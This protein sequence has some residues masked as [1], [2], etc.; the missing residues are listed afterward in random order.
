MPDKSNPKVPA[1]NARFLFR[2][3]IQKLNAS[4]LAHVPKDVQ[5]AIVHVDEIFQAP[6]AF[7]KT[8]GKQITVK[9]A[10][11]AKPK[12]GEQL[13]FHA[14]GWLFG[15][16]VA[17][18]SL[19]QEKSAPG[20]TMLEE[21][22]SD[23]VRNF[24]NRE[25]E[26]RVSGAAMVVEGQVSSIHLPQAQSIAAAASRPARPVSEHDPKWREAVV[27]VAMVHKGKPG[28]KQVVIRFPSSTDVQWYRA[29]KFHTGDRGV[30][31]LQPSTQPPGA[32]KGAKRGGPGA[33]VLAATAVPGA[34][35]YTALHPMDFHPA[36]KLDTVASVIRTAVASQNS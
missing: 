33:A 25:L 30:W 36:N 3:T 4:L 22:A 5:T 34:P 1:G 8:L 24:A 9:L 32:G 19:K 20:K 16:S 15:D 17:V 2:G 13:L 28:T 18:E 6:P 11:G 14:N 31:L 35:V 23:P 27:D 26:R 21:P 12:T 29:P 10:A 7:A